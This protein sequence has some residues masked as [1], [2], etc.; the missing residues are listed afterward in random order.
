MKT[1]YTL[2]IAGIVVLAAAL[3]LV[4]SGIINVS[5]RAPHS[6]PINWLLSTASDA[7]IQRHASDIRAPDLSDPQLIAAGA[8]DFAAMCAGCHGGPGLSRDAAGQGLNPQAPDLAHVA[9]HRSP[10]E[11]FWVTREGIRMTGMPAWGVTHDDSALWPVVALVMQLPELDASGF[12]KLRQ[13]GR[14]L[15]HHG[16]AETPDHDHGGTNDHGGGAHHND[17]ADEKGDDNGPPGHEGHD[18]DH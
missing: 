17:H 18:H 2:A 4:Y 10:E 7:S 16:D 1:I 6:G 12:E 13:Q 9:E 11:V 5:A 15:S 3:G 8:S 14:T